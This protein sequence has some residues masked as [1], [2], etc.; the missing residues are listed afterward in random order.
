M[1]RSPTP[2]TAASFLGLMVAFAVMVRLAAPFWP[3]QIDDV[4]ISLA[5][6]WEWVEHGALQWST[7]ERVEG[8]SNFLLVVLLAAG[9]RIGLDGGLFAKWIELIAATGLLLAFWARAP[10][11][12]RGFAVLLA[13]A[14]WAPFSYWAV[15]GLETMLFALL[16][17]V[18][19]RGSDRLATRF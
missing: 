8:Y 11:D 16:L 10:R 17:V 19:H 2:A 1:S 14:T 12:V 13:L 6:A 3:G 15:M 18:A 4:F 5:Y 7:G 9:A